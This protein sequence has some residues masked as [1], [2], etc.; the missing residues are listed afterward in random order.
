MRSNF[1]YV[2]TVIIFTALFSSCVI[3]QGDGAK[4]KTEPGFFLY[5]ST[6]DEAMSQYLFCL[7]AALKID[8]YLSE[9]DELKKDEIED[10]FFLNYKIRHK[11]DTCILVSVHSGSD[12]VF[13][14]QFLTRGTSLR[15]EN[16]Y[17]SVSLGGKDKW[18]DLYRN[19]ASEY[20]VRAEEVNLGDGVL[21]GSTGLVIS[22]AK[23]EDRYLDENSVYS[24]SISGWGSYMEK[25]ESSGSASYSTYSVEYTVEEKLSAYLIPGL[26]YYPSYYV[27]M[28]RY[29]DGA[30][31]MTVSGEGV[32]DD[33]QK[34]RAELSPKMYVPVVDIT[35]RG[36]TETWELIDYRNYNRY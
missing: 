20:A 31:S 33:V 25:M 6:T 15:D 18:I 30:L 9:T 36:V 26:H 19:T 10:M 29:H 21:L 24:F 8:D 35:Y 3:D 32:V 11:G 5:A 28:F 34:V 2:I 17:W 14:I 7:D 27:G 16:A 22:V 13:D 23:F 1:K 12:G 4:R